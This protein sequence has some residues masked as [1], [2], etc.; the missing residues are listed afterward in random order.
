MGIRMCIYWVG[1]I[2]KAVGLAQTNQKEIN[3]K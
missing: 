2:K 3:N 1:D